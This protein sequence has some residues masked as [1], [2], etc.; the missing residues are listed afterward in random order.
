MKIFISYTSSDKEWA[1]WIGWEL[2]RAGHEPFIH[3]WEVGPGGNIAGWME[4][5]F[6]Q[7]DRLIG[8]FS[9][10]YCEAAFSQ[11]E[12]WAAYWKDPRGRDG[13]FVPIEVRRVSEWPAMVD[14]LKRLSLV[15]LDESEA[16]RRL[17]AFLQPAQSPTEKPTFPRNNPALPASGASF[18]DGGEPLGLNPPSF[19]ATT[20]IEKQLAEPAIPITPPNIDL[21]LRCIDDHEPKP[22]IFGRDAEIETI[23]GA[24]LEHKTVLVAGG[25]GMGKTAVAIAALYD[26][27]VIA[28][29]GRRRI[30]ASLETTTEPRAILAKLVEALGLPPTG[31]EASLL[32]ILEAN[33]AEKP[34]AAIL[35][36]A[37]T[38]FDTDRDAAERFLKL[39]TQVR[40]SSLVITI[41]GVAP[42]ISGT[43]QIGDL[44]KLDRNAARD[45]FLEVAGSSFKDDPDLL[46]LLQALDGHALS[47]RLVAAQAIGSPS[48]Q[49]LWESWEEVHAEILRAYGEEEGRLTSVRASLAL[50]LDNKR[51]KATPFARRLM[52]LLAFLPGGLQETY[53]HSLLGDRGVVTKAKAHEAVVCLHQLRLVERRL[54][55]RLRMLTP[56]RECVKTDARPV[57]EDQSRLLDRY[58]TL[59]DRAFSIGSRDWGKFRDDVEAEADNL[60]AVCDLAVATKITHPKL[61]HAL[62]GLKTFHIFSGRTAV[63]SLAKAAAI[64][65]PKP[66]SRLKAISAEYLAD[67]AVAQLRLEAAHQLF[68]EALKI[69]RD[70]DNAQGEVRCVQGLGDIAF[71]RSDLRSAVSYYNRT[72]ELSRLTG[73]ILN[74]ANSIRS[75]GQIAHMQSDNTV[76]LERFKEASKLYRQV[77]D[78]LGE[79][80]CI[81]SIGETEVGRSD[82]KAHERFITAID[83]FRQIG[84]TG[85]EAKCVQCLGNIARVNT[86]YVLAK[87]HYEEALS[88]YRRVGDIG[89]EAETMI[90]LGQIQR[91]NNQSDQGLAAINTGFDLYLKA[92]D[93]LDQAVT[94]WRAIRIAL[95][96]DNA[97][98]AN[99]YREL[100]KSSWVTIGRL[101]LVSEWI[102]SA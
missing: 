35:D 40:G 26:P 19:P 7:A 68:D 85:G 6:K 41:R 39:A 51:M 12:R 101:D 76:A 22:Q 21:N 44:P 69:H 24:L 96:C 13:F 14:A 36:N 93:S 86:N 80:N 50:S 1:Q 3:D 102:D 78:L 63:G 31:D 60:D 15:D 49:G 55:R 34:F 20:S 99:K 47:I 57:S 73:S 64:L 10:A 100:A 38:V 98:E 53:V 62:R 61:M 72:L 77:G 27:R 70:I 29:F 33:A 45:A 90:R 75:L 9:D 42:P 87:A 46:H 8:V 82:D 58:L 71:Q 81:L 79:A 25:P 94:G 32:R 91:N 28:S 5:R 88:L 23:V 11:S 97:S 16:S 48:L 2:Q 4:Q 66:S 30:F 56:L 83:L 65:R 52:G 84:N 54:D 18:V 89:G 67:V 74:A 95:T 37:E 17:I 92:T 43:V 59:A